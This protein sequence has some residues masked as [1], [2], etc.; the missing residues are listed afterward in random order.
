MLE[1][2][3]KSHKYQVVMP[4]VLGLI[5]F[6]PFEVRP[7]TPVLTLLNHPWKPRTQSDSWNTGR[8]E[9][10][11]EEALVQPRLPQASGRFGH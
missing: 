4:S 5:Y 10:E 6:F 1:L 3:I 2:L 8:F 9:E 11:L 7:K